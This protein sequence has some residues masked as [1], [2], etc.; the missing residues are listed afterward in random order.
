MVESERKKQSRKS[1]QKYLNTFKN[2]WIA[3]APK[4][5]DSL[6][7]RIPLSG[8]N[9]H[10]KHQMLISITDKILPNISENWCTENS[11]A[12]LW[13][14]KSREIKIWKKKC[15]LLKVIF[16]FVFLLVTAN[17]KTTLVFCIFSYYLRKLLIYIALK[18]VLFTL[19]D[20][21]YKKLYHRKIV[22]T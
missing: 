9:H 15:D 17:S 14:I 4:L 2:I 11:F 20:F 21:W 19:K 10:V 6:R 18:F 8:F 16:Q 5:R 12:S 22:Y 3:I 13:T 1:E 7:H